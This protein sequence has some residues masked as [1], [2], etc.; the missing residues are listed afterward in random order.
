MVQVPNILMKIESKRCEWYHH[1]PPITPKQ[2][3]SVRPPKKN[4]TPLRRSNAAVT[5]SSTSD[6][7]LEPVKK[8]ISSN[9]TGLDS[10]VKKLK[11]I[12][13]ISIVM[14]HLLLKLMKEP[15][16]LTAA[17]LFMGRRVNSLPYN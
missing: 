6:K 13:K 5:S 11:M 10:S 1:P 14:I 8:D 16:P 4:L 12:K 2:F 3:E 15:V 9:K 17:H 7:M